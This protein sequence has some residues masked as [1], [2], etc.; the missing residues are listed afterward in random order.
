MD[1]RLRKAAGCR[2]EAVERAEEEDQGQGMTDK[3]LEEIYKAA[4]RLG[5]HGE[6]LRT[7]SAEW[8]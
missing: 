1:D 4:D 2:R 7:M 8:R 3:I 5:A 6:H